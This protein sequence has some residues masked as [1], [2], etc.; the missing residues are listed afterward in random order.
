MSIVTMN[1][2]IA[3]GNE[4]PDQWNRIHSAGVNIVLADNG[5]ELQKYIAQTFKATAY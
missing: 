5:L 4:T 3:G 2:T 1:Q